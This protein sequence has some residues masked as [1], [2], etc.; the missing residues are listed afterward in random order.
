VN[1]DM[2]ITGPDISDI[3]PLIGTTPV[4]G[5]NFQLDVNVDNQITGPD[6]SDIK[7]LIGDL[8]TCP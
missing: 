1:G 2:Q 5:T 7:P 3:K 8:L 4:D 6:I